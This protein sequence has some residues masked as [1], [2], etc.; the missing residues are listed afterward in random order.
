VQTY[1]ATTVSTYA[2][3]WREPDGRVFVGRLVLGSRT[4]RLEGRPRGGDGAAVER[5]FGYDELS[6]LRV[7]NHHADRL[8]GR[9]A[10]V[11]ERADGIYLVADAGLGAPVVQELVER[12]SELRLTALRKTTVV[13]PL[14]EDALERVRALVAHGPPFDP[15]RTQLTR[16]EL[17][18]TPEQA[19][20]TFEAETDEGISTLLDELDLWTAVAAWDELVAG[21]PRLAEV[22]YSWERPDQG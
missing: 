8:D 6:A 9:P 14:K 15:A 12:L 21:P 22:A 10:L 2:V 19:I 4:L 3:T 16:H 13:V 7:G 20:F 11:V 5:Q 18:L 17:L 1:P